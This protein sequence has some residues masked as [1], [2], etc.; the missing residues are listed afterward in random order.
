MA[1][2]DHPP[3]VADR[4]AGV[5]G[6]RL[7]GAV[8]EQLL[9]VADVSAAADE[10]RRGGVPK[11]VRRDWVRDLRRTRGAAYHGSDAWDAEARPGAREEKRRLSRILEQLLSHSLEVERKRLS[12]PADERHEAVLPAL[13][14]ADEQFASGKVDVASPRAAHSEPRSPAP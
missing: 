10:L 13:A 6:R 14:V 3:Q 5:D 2:G 11:R 12:S 8:A 7:H 9:H 4:D 1:A